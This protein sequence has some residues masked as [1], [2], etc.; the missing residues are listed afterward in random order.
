MKRR[1]FSGTRLAGVVRRR[2]FTHLAAVD[3]L[4][5]E[6]T[7]RVLFRSTPFLDYIDLLRR[8]QA[9]NRDFT[10]N[11]PLPRFAFGLTGGF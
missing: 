8:C 10:R 7:K 5:T 2:P 4:S 9:S 1:A 6:P 11:P 3:A